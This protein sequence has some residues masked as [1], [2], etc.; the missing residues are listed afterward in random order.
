MDKKQII[1][2]IGE[3]LNMILQGFNTKEDLVFIANVVINKVRKDMDKGEV[4]WRKKDPSLL[5][6]IID[7]ITN[8]EK[9]HIEKNDLHIVS[10]IVIRT[11][12]EKLNV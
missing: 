5:D 2:E 4:V 11:I 9:Y 1:N 8:I 12:E 3:D 6:D 10:E 7:K